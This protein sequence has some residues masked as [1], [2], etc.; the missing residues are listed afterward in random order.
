MVF[1][2][3]PGA[4]AAVTECAKVALWLREKLE[5]MDLESVPKTSGSK[6]LQIYVPL[7]TPVDFETT[8]TLSHA[9]RTDARVRASR[10]RCFAYEH[11]AAQGKGIHRLEPER[12]VEDDGRGV[13]A[14]SRVKGPPFPLLCSG[15]RS[16]FC[17]RR[18]RS[19][20]SRVRGS[21]CTSCDEPDEHGDLFESVEN[22]ASDAFPPQ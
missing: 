3:D 2:L 17:R 4:P 21:R 20:Q 1:D 13:L 12:P 5:G 7:N 10:A 14:P 16:S 18:R 11:A 8:K 15:K 9:S 6:G 19:D 22:D